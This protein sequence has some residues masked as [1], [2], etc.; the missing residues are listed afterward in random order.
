M[1][2]K[3][4]SVK[5]V[6]MKYYQFN[7]ML[8]TREKSKGFYNLTPRVTITAFPSWTISQKENHYKLTSFMKINV[9]VFKESVGNLVTTICKETNTHDQRAISHPNVIWPMVFFP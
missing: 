1:L 9:K 5:Y 4:D 8:V 7:T 3:K 2:E 6:V